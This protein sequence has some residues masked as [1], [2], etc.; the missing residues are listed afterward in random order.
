MD[1]EI[2]EET[3]A[4][5]RQR[6]W[7][8]D[9]DGEEIGTMGRLAPKRIGAG[10]IATPERERG[11]RDPLHFFHQAV[12]ITPV[13]VTLICTAGWGNNFTPLGAAGR[14]KDFGGERFA[15]C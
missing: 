3:P 1:L 7:K 2:L 9:Q 14:L 12:T 4:G 10:S 6:D 15:C 8:G 5:H 13:T 11:I